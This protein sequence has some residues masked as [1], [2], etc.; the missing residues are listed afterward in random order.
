MSQADAYADDSNRL[1]SRDEL[2]EIY[3][4]LGDQTIV[5]YC[6]TGHWAATNWFVMSEVLGLDNVRLYDGSMVEW[7]A[8]SDLPLDTSAMSNMDKLKKLMGDLLG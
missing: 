8:N 5:S 4:D 2:T 1:K 6:N 3:D 7:T